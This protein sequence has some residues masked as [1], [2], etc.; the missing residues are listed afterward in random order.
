MLALSYQKLLVSIVKQNTDNKDVGNYR[1]DW[2]YGFSNFDQHLI[3]R[4][5]LLTRDSNTSF[6]DQ[7]LFKK[8][9]FLKKI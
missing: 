1:V 7:N 6:F 9:G 4:L 3:R 8:N 5:I 2:V